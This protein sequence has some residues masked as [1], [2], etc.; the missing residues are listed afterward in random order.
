MNIKHI[1]I[2]MVVLGVS[3]ISLSILLATITND[4]YV[5]AQSPTKSNNNN[6]TAALIGDNTSETKNNSE[7]L[8]Y[9]TKPGNLTHRLAKDEWQPHLGQTN[10]FVEWWYF[11]ALLHDAAGN[12]YMLFD[13]IFKYDSK[14]N[15]FVAAQ[16]EI[17]AKMEP[18]QSYIMSQVELSN[19]NEGFHFDEVDV[20]LMD[21]IS[22]WDTNNNT[23]MY[24]TPK[25]HW[26][27]GL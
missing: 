16:P 18:R 19:Y 8:S 7:G 4:N 26:F 24:N 1:M 21:R 6:Q 13:T 11:T 20:S 22:M 25:Q 27:M 9:D 17:A 3:S 5:L 14:G 2:L 15:P 10:S 12:K 23:L